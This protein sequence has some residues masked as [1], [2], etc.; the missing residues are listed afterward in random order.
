MIEYTLSGNVK[1]REISGYYE[2]HLNLYGLILSLIYC[3]EVLEVSQSIKEKNCG[4]IRIKAPTVQYR[5][6]YIY[7]RICISISIHIQDLGYIQ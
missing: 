4:G 3:R 5:I 2:V 6:A 1:A 7:S